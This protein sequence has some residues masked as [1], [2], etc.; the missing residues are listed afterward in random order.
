MQTVDEKPETIHLYV[1]REEDQKRPST[2]LPLLFALLCL[3]GIVALTLYS[4]DHP[5]YEYKTLRVPAQFLPLQTFT[6]TAPIIPT[7]S[8]TY[9]AIQAHG[10]LTVYNGSILSQRIPQGMILTAGN[11]IEVVTNQSVFVPNGNPPAYGIASVSAHAITAGVQGNLPSLSISNVYG[12]SLY[13][14]NLTA[15][16]GGQ[17]AYSVKVVTAQDRQTATDTARSVLT[18]QEAAIR[19]FLA[20]PCKESLT[21]VKSLL[22]L[23][24]T[25]QFVTYRLPS[26][27]KV[28]SVRLV[29]SD[30]L[31][32]VRFVAR[33]RRMWV[34]QLAVSITH[35][36]FTL[37]VIASRRVYLG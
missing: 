11:G 4:S 23:S 25:C 18:S 8:K 1:V 36:Q 34:K 26:Y 19:A 28:V 27:M 37:D 21:S 14:R 13:I 12:T 20:A 7:G 10:T 30:L 31:I 5:A 29:G 6:A 32:D 33:P 24:W 17:D 35:C 2:L 3:V 15:F 9:P 22:Q 16:H